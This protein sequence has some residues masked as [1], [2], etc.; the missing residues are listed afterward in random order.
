[1]TRPSRCC[2]QALTLPAIGLL[3]IWP[4]ALAAQGTEPERTPALYG[5]ALTTWAA[6]SG[7][8]GGVLL[9][10]QG[11]TTVHQSS[12]GSADPLA[13]VLL[14]SLSKAITATCIAKLIEEGRLE[15]STPLQVALSHH[16][17][18]YGLPA[19]PRVLAITI[20]QLVLHRAGFSGRPNDALTTLTFRTFLEKNST[21]D[22]HFGP[23]LAATL[24]HPLASPPGVRYAYSNAGY[25]AL[26]AIIEEATREEYENACRA[27]VLAP[28]GIRNAKLDPLWRVL[29]SYAGWS[30]SAADYLRFFEI[31]APDNRFLR[32]DIRTWMADKR[33]KS[34]GPQAG[35]WYALGIRIDLTSG[36]RLRISHTG[37]W[38]W[39]QPIAKDGPLHSSTGAFVVRYG[40][41]TSLFAAF[42]P[43]PRDIAERDL[44]YRRLDDAMRDANQKLQAGPST[45]RRH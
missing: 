24:H 9:V 32:S 29:S 5:A 31:F 23:L 8:K 20:E 1:M 14:A 38:P 11:R 26:G 43:I 2:Q 13:P 42:W 36:G 19:D 28:L 37:A 4:I 21:R 22:T 45:A 3:A 15:W 33:G 6:V 17:K 27:R 12:V 25:L 18:V 40:N 35:H 7:V 34:M 39:T 10:S 16:L 41:G 30:L 44:A